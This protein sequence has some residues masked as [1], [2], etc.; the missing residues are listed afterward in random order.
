MQTICPVIIIL[1]DLFIPTRR[2]LSRIF[3]PKN[4]LL[5]WNNPPYSPHLAP[6]YF[7]LFQKIKNALKGLRFQDTEDIQENVTTAEKAVPQQELQKSFRQWKNRL[8]KFT[9]VQGEHFT[10][11]Q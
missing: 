5:K 3:C 10:S 8:A 9:A 2:S 7:W 4:R 1:L 11:S 6:N